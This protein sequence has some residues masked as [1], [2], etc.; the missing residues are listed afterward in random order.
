MTGFPDGVR[1]GC[2]NGESKMAQAFWPQAGKMMLPSV[3][4]GRTVQEQVWGEEQEADLARSVLGVIPDPGITVM[5]GP[6]PVFPTWCS[7]LY[8][9]TKRG[10]FTLSGGHTASP[11]PGGLPAVP[12]G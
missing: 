10:S 2:E 9:G 7:S 12:P 11:C 6:C 5:P 3:E 8:K 4:M 1:A